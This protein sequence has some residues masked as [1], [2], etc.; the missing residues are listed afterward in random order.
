MLQDEMIA[1]LTRYKYEL[2]GILSR[3]KKTSE[4]IHI[5]RK[6]DARFREMA[7][8][9]RDLFDDEFVDGQRHSRPVIG[10]FNESI[11]NYLETPS[12]YGVE[13]VKGVVVSALARLERNPLALR[14]AALDE[15]SKDAR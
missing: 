10:Y 7:L 11:A 6:D 9:L 3:F 15:K 2:E 4:G 5:N 1:T 8:E 12:Y 13:S 14:R